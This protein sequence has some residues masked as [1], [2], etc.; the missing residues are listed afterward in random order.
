LCRAALANTFDTVIPICGEVMLRTCLPLFLLLFG[1]PGFAACTGTD[2]RAGLTNAERAALDSAIKATP[3]ANGNHWVAKRGDQTIH[4]IGTMHL[5]HPR[6]PAIVDGLKPVISTA[7]L[8]LVEMTPTET[9]A[10][11]AALARDPSLMFITSGPTL[12]ELLPDPDWQALRSAMADRGIPAFMAAKMQPWMLTMLLGIPGCAMADANREN[13]LDARLMMQADAADVPILA[14][15]AYDAIFRLL[16]SEPMDQQVQALIASLPAAKTSENQFATLM[17]TYFEEASA[18]AW[19]MSRLMAYRGVDLPKA[20]IDA[21]FQQMQDTLLT[22]RNH[23]WMDVILNRP[24]PN[25]VIAVGALHLTGQTG[26]LSLL[27]QAGFQME[28]AAF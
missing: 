17:G 7:D 4:L 12:P 27:E 13:G 24:E 22:R 21:M 5:N 11:Q 18:E 10:M 26:L 23:A 9:Q 6:W 20:E 16:G 1:L 15:E 25:L 19:E 3:F 14:L 8:V 2:E 28:R